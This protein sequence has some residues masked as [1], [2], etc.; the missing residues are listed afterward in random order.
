MSRCH[1]HFAGPRFRAAF[2]LIEL[3]VVLALIAILSAVI[4]PEMR[5]TL[6]D[7]VLRSSARQ[8]VDAFSLAS[9]RAVALS[10]PHRVRVD[11]DSGEYVIE[12]QSGRRGGGHP[13]RAVADLTGGGGRLDSRVSVQIHP[14]RAESPVDEPL[15]APSP[16]PNAVTFYADG[17]A[18]AMEVSLQDRLGGGLLLRLNP[19]TSRVRIVERSHP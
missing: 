6:E 19:V 2:T 13:F 1:R 9:G 11:R 18:E 10:R 17:T 14:T 5:G 12:A 16:R 8:L 3:M 15:A 4:L 7:A